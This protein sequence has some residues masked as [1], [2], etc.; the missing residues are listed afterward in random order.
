MSS[1]SPLFGSVHIPSDAPDLVIPG[2][3]SLPL[4]IRTEITERLEAEFNSEFEAWKSTATA[5]D[6][7]VLAAHSAE[8]QR[9]RDDCEAQIAELQRIVAANQQKQR[10]R[11]AEV[12]RFEAEKVA[13]SA[14]ITHL[15]S[16]ID[17]IR[18]RHR[19]EEEQARA[20]IVQRRSDLRSERAQLDADIDAALERRSQLEREV[21]ELNVTSQEENRRREAQRKGVDNVRNAVAELLK[22][23]PFSVLTL[24]KCLGSELD[25]V[26]GLRAK[27]GLPPFV[28]PSN[29]KK[30]V[31]TDEH[32]RALIGE[33]G[34]QTLQRTYEELEKY[35]RWK[36]AQLNSRK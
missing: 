24:V 18:M 11:A 33:P 13:L 17:A 7:S 8:L 30:I 23:T 25:A 15:N 2:A 19:E 10:D 34:H 4:E 9:I 1:F 16:E 36:V 27:D 12:A 35:Y 20:A 26:N 22:P 3:D 6:A 14:E 31:L 5:P 21:N 28:G 29:G 32:A